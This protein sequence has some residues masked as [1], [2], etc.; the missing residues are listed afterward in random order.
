M[1]ALPLFAFGQAAEAP[2]FVAADVHVAPKSQNQAMRPPS[3]RGERYD[4]RNATMVDLIGLAYGFIATR[5]VGGP[6]WLEMDRFDVIAKVPPQTAPDIQKAML[7]N[8]LSERFKLVV[9][10]EDKPMPSYALTVGK[11]PQLKE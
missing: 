4:V 10:E 5:I 3:G 7:K 11:K 1:C 6:S 8:L 9:R 2:R